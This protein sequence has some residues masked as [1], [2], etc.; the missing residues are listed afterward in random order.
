LLKLIVKQFRKV[1]GRLREKPDV[2]L[3]D[4]EFEHLLL[5]HG[6]VGTSPDNQRSFKDVRA[7][8]IDAVDNGSSLQLAIALKVQPLHWQDKLEK[9]LS[10]IA[11][12]KNEQ[13]ISVLLPNREGEPWPDTSDPLGHSDWRVR[14]NAAFILG[15]LEAKQ[16][17]DRMIKCLDD[18]ASSASPA[19]CHVA[20]A[21]AKMQGVQSRNALLAHI[22]D[23]EPWFRVDTAV[24]LTN[25]SDALVKNTLMQSLL[26][27]NP[28][29]DYLAVS[30]SKSF[31]VLELIEDQE[32]ITRKGG[33]QMLTGLIEAATQTFNPEVLTDTD[34]EACANKL[35]EIA[36]TKIDVFLLRAMLGL[37]NIWKD[38]SNILDVANVSLMRDEIHKAT[39]LLNST[40]SENE[41]N[42]VLE[43]FVRAASPTTE[44]E[45]LNAVQLAGTLKFKSSLN[46]LLSLLKLETISREEIVTAIGTIGDGSGAQPLIELALQLYKLEERTGPSLSSVPVVE[47]DTP[48]SKLYW[49]ILQA[50]GNLP[51]KATTKFLF[52]AASDFAPDKRQQIMDSL[53]NLFASFTTEDTEQFTELVKGNLEDPSATVKVSALQG[54]AALKAVQHLDKVLKMSES[55]EPSISRQALTTLGRLVQSGDESVIKAIK[56]KLNAET[57][58]KRKSRLAEVVR[59]R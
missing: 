46:N 35:N 8:I 20:Y 1:M 22:N 32:E 10:E 42:R 11:P 40:E 21:M 27:I 7:D 18:T 29:S 57:D 16:G 6:L 53:N 5:Y 19:Y 43:K 36:A 37:T 49:R 23:P 28:L 15:H 47:Q 24:A 59:G 13:L 25:F 12:T 17:I 54:V 56:E 30:L 52:D 33:C 39:T 14:A 9:I 4:H 48:K 58:A 41:V 51:G 34:L 38:K 26:T 3:D 45:L 55:Q 44:T 31:P 50:L 2:R